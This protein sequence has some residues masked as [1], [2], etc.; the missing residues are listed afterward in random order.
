M[1]K[2]EMREQI[3]QMHLDGSSVANIVYRTGVSRTTARNILREYKLID[4]IALS[5]SDQKWVREHWGKIHDYWKKLPAQ[6][7]K[8]QTEYR[9][10]HPGD[11]GIRTPTRPDGKFK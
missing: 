10:V 9:K 3:V 7:N 2:P 8:P 6:K 5:E 4:D 11:Q 1:I